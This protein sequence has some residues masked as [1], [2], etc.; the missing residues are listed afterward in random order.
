MDIVVDALKKCLALAAPS[1]SCLHLVSS[2]ILRRAA[3]WAEYR[4]PDGKSYFFS[5]VTKQSVWVKPPALVEL[6]G[7]HSN[8]F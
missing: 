7:K 2:D 4:T 8:C 1:G 3:E 5:L 6:D